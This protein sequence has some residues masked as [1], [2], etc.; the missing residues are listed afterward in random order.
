MLFDCYFVLL[1]V[2][3][4]LIILLGILRSDDL[5]LDAWGLDIDKLWAIM[6]RN[7]IRKLLQPSTIIHK[8]ENNIIFIIMK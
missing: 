2:Y 8:I 3:S 7:I 1:T 5:Y 6:M 4:F